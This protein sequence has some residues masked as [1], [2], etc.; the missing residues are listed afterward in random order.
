M[1]TR[2]VATVTAVVLT[3]TFTYWIALPDVTGSLPAQALLA[4]VVY[5]LELL[6]ILTLIMAAVQGRI[7]LIGG[8]M[9]VGLI[10]GAAPGAAV[11]PMAVFLPA[12]L[13]A[14]VPPVVLGL[15][16]NRSWHAGK[17]FGVASLLMAAFV[18]VIY[19]QGSRAITEQ[20][21][22]LDG[23]IENLVTAPL[24]AQGYSAEAIN[25][26]IDQIRI[27]VK[28]LVR[29]LPSLIIL[30]AIGQ[31][32]VAF[33]LVEWY[34]TRQDSYFPGF[35]PFVYWKMP[36]KLLYLLGTVVILRLAVDGGVQ[37]AAD[38]FICVLLVVY[39]VCGLSLI[40][41]FLR[42]LRLPGFVRAIL[43]IGFFLMPLQGL[44]LP[45]R[46]AQMITLTAA[47][48]PSLAGLFDSFFDFRKVRAHTLG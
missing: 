44:M 1:G 25:G 36:E 10:L 23:V 3:A 48:V 19:L 37:T 16:V 34:Y 24:L 14:V 17:G 40:E 20:M 2:K 45:S 35:G 11:M 31:L 4:A 41:H 38:N 12:W 9:V 33:L 32:F 21:N 7:R 13:K 30:S 5:L 29:L 43:Y 27:G 22:N 42:R 46:A 6:L 18:V 8:A 26:L 39:A 15:L 47:L 28:F